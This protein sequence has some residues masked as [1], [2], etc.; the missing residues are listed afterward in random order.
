MG[1]RYIVVPAPG[2][3]I[4]RTAI[5]S[6]HSSLEDAI[7]RSRHLGHRSCVRR[8]ADPVTLSDGSVIDGYQPGSAWLSVYESGNPIIYRSPGRP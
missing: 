5:D 8:A 4:D 2:C 1:N 6:V 3:Y 7:R